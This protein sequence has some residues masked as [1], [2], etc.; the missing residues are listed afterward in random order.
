MSFTSAIKSELC[1]LELGRDCCV[2]AELAALVAT[3]GNLSFSG[4]GA[5]SLNIVTDH[6][7]IARR[8]YK[9]VKHVFGLSPVILAR[10]KTRL[11][12]NLSYL[13]RI[14]D[15]GQ[16]RRV[17]ERLDIIDGESRMRSGDVSKFAAS[18]CCRRAYLRGC[19]LAGGSVSNPETNGYHLEIATELPSHA[20]NIRLLLAEI[21]VKAGIVSRKRQQVVYVKDSEQIAQVLSTIGS[22]QGRLHFENARILKDLR[23]RVNR[24]VNCETANVSKTVEAAQRQVAAIR[25]LSVSPGLEALSPGLRQVAR[26]RL[27]NPSATLDE[28]G[29]LAE[30]PLSKSAVNYR[31]RRLQQ[32]ADQSRD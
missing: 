6:A 1:R 28:L 21:G 30:P 20:D 8:I 24:L 16:T 32:L 7:Y 17:M 5:M 23:N 14:A 22:N 4:R 10:K 31:L 29:Q 19:F 12:K 27:E 3:N 2:K 15:S 9:L 25:M 11:R 13:V 26:L 18:D